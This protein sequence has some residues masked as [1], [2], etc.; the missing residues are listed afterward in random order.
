MQHM[1]DTQ[2]FPFSHKTVEDTD[3]DTGPYECAPEGAVDLVQR[4]PFSVTE[5]LS[6]VGAEELDL[7]WQL[8]GVTVGR[9]RKIFDLEYGT[10]GSIEMDEDAFI[11]LIMRTNE[12]YM[13]PFD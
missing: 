5:R 2:S 4:D 10:D 11:A 3:Q 6:G 7:K 8:M 13:G 1:Q 12:I 9:G